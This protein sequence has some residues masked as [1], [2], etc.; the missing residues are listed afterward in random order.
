MG[1]KTAT[2][3]SVEATTAVPT[4]DVPRTTAR[5]GSSP[6]SRQRA[7][8]STTTMPESTSMPMPRASPPRLMMFSESPLRFIGAKTAATETGMASE[9]TAVERKSRRNR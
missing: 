5:S 4:S 6:S 8:L 2:V 7:M 1:K 9:T 3:V